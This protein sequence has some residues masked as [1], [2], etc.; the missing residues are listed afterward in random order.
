MIE[1]GL[2]LDTI[3]KI[4]MAAKEVV[5]MQ[6]VTGEE[7]VTMH[8]MYRQLMV[9]SERLEAFGKD[10][11]AVKLDVHAIKESNKSTSS[12]NCRVVCPLGCG[13]DFKRVRELQDAVLSSVIHLPTGELFARSFVQI[14]WHQ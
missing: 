13:A 10:L 1:M 5:T 12:S 11:S 8:M 9:M 3:A 14:Y 6:S 4:S 2:H 7:A